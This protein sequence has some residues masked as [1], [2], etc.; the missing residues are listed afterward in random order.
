MEEYRI[1]VVSTFKMK[2]GKTKGSHFL[3]KKKDFEDR[4]SIY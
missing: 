3:S 2:P 1:Y 4:C